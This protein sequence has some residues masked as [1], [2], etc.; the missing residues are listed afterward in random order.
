MALGKNGAYS[1][2]DTCPQMDQKAHL[3]SWRS[4]SKY[5]GQPRCWTPGSSLTEVRAFRLSPHLLHVPH[6]GSWLSPAS[7]CL[8]YQT[9]LAGSGCHHFQDEDRG[10]ERLKVTRAG[11]LDTQ[12]AERGFSRGPLTLHPTA[13]LLNQNVLETHICFIRTHCEFKI[14]GPKM[15]TLHKKL[16]S[17]QIGTKGQ[18]YFQANSLKKILESVSI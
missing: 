8:S 12:W 15:L 6:V 16:T 18:H 13:F 9:T 7:F 1:K 17:P 3:S 10:S 11:V 5:P 4:L 2:A 14:C